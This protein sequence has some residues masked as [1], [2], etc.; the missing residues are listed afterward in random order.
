MAW[1]NP[2]VK[3]RESQSKAALASGSK[4]KK[5]GISSHSGLS[6]RGKAKASTSNTAMI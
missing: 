1:S 6:A 4:T 5:T 2:R 3:L